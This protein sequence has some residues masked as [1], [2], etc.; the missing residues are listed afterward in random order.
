MNRFKLVCNFI[1]VIFVFFSSNLFSQEFVKSSLEECDIDS[2]LIEFENRNRA[3]LKTYRNVNIDNNICFGIDLNCDTLTNTK[4]IKV[5]DKHIQEEIG[6]TLAANHV[7]D[8]FLSFIYGKFKQ[9]KIELDS[10]NILFFGF[11]QFFHDNMTS[12][13]CFFIFFNDNIAF[14]FYRSTKDNFKIM[15]MRLNDLEYFEEL[16]L[17][18]DNK[19]LYKDEV[20]TENLIY[21]LSI[22]NGNVQYKLISNYDRS[23]FESKYCSQF[24]I[25]KR[26]EK[27]LIEYV[28]EMRCNIKS[29]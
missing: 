6:K 15:E 2:T 28:D 24:D 27:L 22:L 18:L 7:Y 21:I 9:K 11:N 10:L 17:Q 5:F 8:S 20:N 25:F 3:F 1:L 14:I 19:L 16:L 12:R 23:N 29:N 4:N 26:I 13:A